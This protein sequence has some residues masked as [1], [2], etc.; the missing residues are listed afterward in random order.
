[1]ADNT[2]I[3]WT[4]ATWNPTVG[5]SVISPGC[6]NCYAMKMAGR[7]EAMGQPIYRGHTIKTKAGFVWNGKVAASNRGQ[8]IKPLTWKK[9]RRI[10]VN[11][12]S[13]LFHEDMP[14]E[15]IDEVFAV[16]ALCPQHT[17]QVLTK[18]A[19]RMR[20]YFTKPLTGPWAG[21]ASRINSRTGI[22]E[23][24]VDAEWRVH[25]LMV[26]MLKDCP[27]EGLN[28]AIEWQ[29]ANGY[30][31]GGFMC[32]WPLP[33]VW[34]GVSVED[35]AR[36]PRLDDLRATPAA[37][38]F[39]SAEPLLE[40]LGEIDLTGIDQVITGGES[41]PKRRPIEAD[42]MRSIRDQCAAAGVAFFG[43]QWDKVRP[44][45]PDLMVRQMPAAG[46]VG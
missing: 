19:D 33:N 3:E 46:G 17:F 28:R 9:P 29:E 26:R 12:M 30:G 2:G 6:T 38:R 34:L 27:P 40:D 16:M 31:G 20:E 36:L 24:I 1:M 44:L 39:V 10:F 18:R 32:D 11:S 4:D 13:D 45:P 43:K 25:E 14:G 23:P 42:W 21:R 35:R 37:V 7:L 8:M 41:G 22:A 15:V 5:C